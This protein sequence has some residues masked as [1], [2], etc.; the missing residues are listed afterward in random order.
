MSLLIGSEE[1]PTIPSI[2][3]PDLI[4]GPTLDSIKTSNSLKTYISNTLSRKYLN[5]PTSLDVTNTPLDIKIARARDFT[6]TS[7]SHTDN[8]VLIWANRVVSF[9]LAE[10]KR[11]GRIFSPLVITKVITSAN[12]ISNFSPSSSFLDLNCDLFPYHETQH[13]DVIEGTVRVANFVG[14]PPTLSHK[15]DSNVRTFAI[16]TLRDPNINFDKDRDF[17]PP[18]NFI[19]DFP[20]TDT[21]LLKTPDIPSIHRDTI[22]VK[23]RKSKTSFSSSHPP[24][25]FCLLDPFPNLGSVVGRLSQSDP[26]RTVLKSWP[27]S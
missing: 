18:I 16:G 17:Y 23:V 22:I 12:S 13:I 14:N 10:A 2:T 9:D 26:P 21:L 19:P 4:T 27:K 25:L 15:G 6:L 7:H 1:H 11:I 8:S 5:N 20:L 24:T 3:L